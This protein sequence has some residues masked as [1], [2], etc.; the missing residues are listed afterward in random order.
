MRVGE[1]ERGK[2]EES[3]DVAE[4]RVGDESLRDDLLSVI[5]SY[6]DGEKRGRG[7]YVDASGCETWCAG[8]DQLRDDV[9]QDAIPQQLPPPPDQLLLPPVDSRTSP[10]T[11]RCP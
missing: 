8:Y 3:R 10:P 7:T 11:S 4:E 2:S 5:V 6:L 9:L 1:E